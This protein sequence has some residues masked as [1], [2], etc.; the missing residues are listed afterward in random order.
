MGKA[1][2]TVL[3]CFSMTFEQRQ[4]VEWLYNN[5]NN[6]NGLIYYH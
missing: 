2:H 4:V 6:I 1:A 3:F 5:L